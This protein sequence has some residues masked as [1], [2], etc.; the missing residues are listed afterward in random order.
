MVSY[1]GNNEGDV[2]ADVDAGVTIALPKCPCKMPLDWP[3]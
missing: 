2:N 1:I 3:I